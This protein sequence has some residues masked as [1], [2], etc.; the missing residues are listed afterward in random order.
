MINIFRMCVVV[1]FI[2]KN[3]QLSYHVVIADNWWQRS[4]P[5]VVAMRIIELMSQLF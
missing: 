4:I 2:C 3:L 1:A 5:G